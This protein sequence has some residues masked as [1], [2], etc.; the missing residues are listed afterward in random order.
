L[1]FSTRG[2]AGVDGSV[3]LPAGLW[4]P[5]SPF[6]TG[7]AFDQGVAAPAHQRRQETRRGV[8]AKRACAE[9]AADIFRERSSMA[10]SYNH[11][12]DDTAGHPRRRHRF[13]CDQAGQIVEQ[14]Q[15]T[16]LLRNLH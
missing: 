15:A 8:A 6:D 3:G 7:R 2:F 14:D 5:K 13:T 12:V 16:T 9:D 10:L 1:I 11:G 4:R